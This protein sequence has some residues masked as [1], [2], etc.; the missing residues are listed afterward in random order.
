VNFQ[1]LRAVRETVRQNLNLTEAAERLFTS[2]PGVS[3]QIRELED[4]LGVPIFVRKGK[5]FVALT[6]PGAAIVQVIERMLQEAENLKR[7][8][9][10]Y[11]AADVG[12]LTIATT[13]TQARYALPKVVSAFKRKHPQVHLSLQ[14]GNPPQVAE[15]VLRGEAD[16]GIATEALDHYPGLLALPGY[17]W[18]HSVVVPRDHALASAKAIT[19][20]TI[21]Q[22]PII[23]YDPAFTG[24]THIDAAFAARDLKPDIV[25]AAIDADVIKTYVELG[26]GVG[27]VASMAYDAERDHALVAFDASHLFRSNTTRVAIRRGAFLRGFVY[28]F[29]EGFAPALTRRVVEQALA[30]SSE[31]YEL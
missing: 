13:H 11:G 25:I 29:I 16:V 9:K 30:G 14:Q 3:K 6:E 22:H 17:Q 18:S 10:D 21:A 24:R 27:I 8:A 15:M 20:E 23:T 7:V 31:S 5:R 2:Q 1:Q 28:E 19:L 12:A 26:L 4:E